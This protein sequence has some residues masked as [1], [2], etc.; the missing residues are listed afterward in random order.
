MRA[1]AA[2]TLGTEGG[3]ARPLL[4]SGM[5]ASFAKVISFESRDAVSFSRTVTDRAGNTA[6]IKQLYGA[7]DSDVD[8]Y[9]NFVLAEYDAAASDDERLDI[10]M[11]EYYIALWGNGIEA[12]NMYRRT[13]KPG[14]M[15]PGLETSPGAFMKSFFYPADHEQRNPNVV[16]KQVTDPVFWDNGSANVY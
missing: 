15:Q 9:V 16:Q 13:G 7:S 6:T 2:L 14:N 1:E 11:K 10:V 4:E 12:Y 8:D 5:R 3:D